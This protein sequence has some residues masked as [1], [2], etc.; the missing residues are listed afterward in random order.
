MKKI[1]LLSLALVASLSMSAEN[2]TK[3]RV[4]IGGTKA[5]YPLTLVDSLTFFSEAGEAGEEPLPEPDP[6][7]T[8]AE[9][10][11]VF[12]VA[13]GKTVA[14]A[15]GNLQYNAAQGSHYCAYGSVQQ[16]TWRFAEHQYDYIGYDSMNISQSYDGWIDLFGWGTSGYNN[17]AND[18]SALRYQP[19]ETA[20][21]SISTIPTDSVLNCETVEIT[22][23]C[24][25]EYTY[26]DATYNE[27][28]YGPSTNMTD[29]NL[30]GTS[31][32][33]DWGV[34][35]AIS[36][37]GNQAGLWRTL[38]V[39]EWNY[40]FNTRTNAQYLWSSGT[41]N[42]V[43][44]LI[45]LPDNFKKPSDI[46]W[47]YQANNWTTNT[48]TTEQWATLEAL[49][50]VFLPASGLRDGANVISVQYGGYYWSSSY[51]DSGIAYY[52]FFYSDHLNPQDKYNRYYGSS[53]RLV[54]DL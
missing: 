8:P 54:Q 19:L 28:G 42:G 30:T 5:E 7:P 6:T 51:F 10:I 15:A 37:A 4:W 31:A 47:T 39:E 29:K 35:N 16:G 22:G 48:Y 32:N 46:S 2:T 23:E 14:F 43:V 20:R 52:L 50:A 24:E 26:A 38:S 3:L 45:I 53:V 40:L 44:G 11:G 41:V 34:Y 21:S 12:T 27:W 13:E 25:W 9:G 1:Q 17:T 33:Y 36:N 18:P 49:G